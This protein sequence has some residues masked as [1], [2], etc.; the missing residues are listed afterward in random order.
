[1]GSGRVKVSSSVQE[2]RQE[3]GGMKEG[4]QE[5]CRSHQPPQLDGRGH[6]QPCYP[7]PSPD[8]GNAH[9]ESE[10]KSISDPFEF[11]FFLGGATR[12]SPRRIQDG[13]PGG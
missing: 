7:Q 4:W 9:R 13:A 6:Q 3:G 11:P 1:M 8:L 10:F 5:Q 12:P 2:E